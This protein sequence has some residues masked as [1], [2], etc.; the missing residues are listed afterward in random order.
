MYVE[1]IHCVH[2]VDDVHVRQYCGQFIHWLLYKYVLP[3]HEIEHDWPSLDNK[4]PDWQL[5]H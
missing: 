5:K 3:V 4:V 1:L 2:V